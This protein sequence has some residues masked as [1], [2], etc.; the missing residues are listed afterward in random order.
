MHANLSSSAIAF[1][2][3]L[4]ER[5]EFA[6]GRAE[7]HDVLRATE[8]IGIS[9]RTRL[10]AALRSICCGRKTDIAAFDLAF[11][12]YFTSGPPGV[13]QPKHARRRRPQGAGDTD[14]ERLSKFALED[15]GLADGWQAMRARY[16]PSASA[17]PPPPVPGPGYE[18]AVDVANRLVARIRLGRS[19]R[20]RP[21]KRGRRVD[22]R[23]TLRTSLQTGGEIAELRHLGHPL[24]NP[25]FIV[26]V[27]G[28]RSMNEHARAA[29]QIAYALCR[30]SRRTN[31]FCFSTELREITRELR[32]I[33]RDGTGR[34]DGIGEAW[35]GGTRIGASLREFVRK[36]RAKLDEHTYVIVV[37]DGLDVGN[38]ADLEYAM[39]EIQR[40]A[41]AVAWVNPHAGEPGFEPTARGMQAVLPFISA[42]T[43]WAELIGA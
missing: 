6:L 30:R 40:R 17:A 7:T 32:S 21:Q 4:R 15:E 33:P 1:C 24:R 8:L 2:T 19:R 20:W 31:I 37:S 41:A 25:R 39:R 26:L 16:S 11:D 14:N 22:V 23:R 34:L 10:R 12:E 35:G 42:L 13:P 3:L 38:I 9:D 27:D 18:E 28:S 5:H 29:L 43:T 36:F